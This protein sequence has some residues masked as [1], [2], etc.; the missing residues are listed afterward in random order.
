MNGVPKSGMNYCDPI[1]SSENPNSNR[2]IDLIEN[3]KEE[4]GKI[5]QVMGST[6]YG[7]SGSG[8]EDVACM[9]NN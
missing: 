1:R 7:E 6:G 2:R 8:A 5:S 3:K 9:A 4:G